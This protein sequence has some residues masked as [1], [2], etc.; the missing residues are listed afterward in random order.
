MKLELECVHAN[1]QQ[2]AG[3]RLLEEWQLRID[4]LLVD[5]QELIQEKNRLSAQL[6]DVK[7]LPPTTDV[8]RHMTKTEHLESADVN[9]PLTTSPIPTEDASSESSHKEETDRMSQ[10][11]E[12]SKRQRH[13]PGFKDI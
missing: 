5:K 1:E 2:L 12:R 7:K 11:V 13:S 10:P 6:S 8:I 9:M 4:N 3:E